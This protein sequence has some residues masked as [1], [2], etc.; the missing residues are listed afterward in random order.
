MEDLVAAKGDRHDGQVNQREDQGE[1]AGDENPGQPQQS[2][3]EQ[4][5]ARQVHAEECDVEPAEL[6]QGS[7]EEREH[8][9]SVLRAVPE[10]KIPRETP[11]VNP[12]QD[13]DRIEAGI[14][15]ESPV[16][17]DQAL[18]ARSR[19]T[20]VT[21]SAASRPRRVSRS[22]TKPS[23]DSVMVALHYLSGV[24]AEGSPQPEP[25]VGADLAADTP[26]SLSVELL[27]QH[28]GPANAL[29]GVDVIELRE[30]AEQVDS[31]RREVVAH[32]LCV[33]AVCLVMNRVGIFETPRV[34]DDDILLAKNADAGEIADH[35][36]KELTIAQS[37]RRVAAPHCCF[38]DERG[39]SRPDHVRAE[40]T[41]EADA[42]RRTAESGM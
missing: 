41:H 7:H 2:P 17:L 6:D 1:V 32:D 35:P 26:F 22:S 21:G 16:R 11:R 13:L 27:G 28:Q 5:F 24:I 23:I 19:Q 25:H 12:F 20:R 38:G 18:A 42:V 39:R 15:I 36:V 40:E 30:P 29:V 31:D 8:G 9:V 37:I 14:V 10:V 33:L 4:G 3:E 34:T